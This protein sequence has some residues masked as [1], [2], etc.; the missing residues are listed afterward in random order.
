MALRLTLIAHARTIAQKKARF[1][2][3][4]SVEMDGQAPAHSRN[5]FSSRTTRYLCGPEA[6][7]RE[8]AALFSADA[9]L[10]HGLRDCDFGR[11]KGCLLDDIEPEALG[12]W[13]ADWQATPHGGESVEQLCQRTGE[14]MAALTGRGHIV[15][16]TH[17]LVM[18]AALMNV[19]QCPP[20]AFHAIDIEPLSMID[21]RHNGKWRMRV[22]PSP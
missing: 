7:T 16:V 13:M 14:W 19:L 2:A 6:R 11:W 1:A 5:L 20:S 8:T 10:D 4:E 18:R 15:A 21:L 3:D 22:S 9:Q 12:V 17:P